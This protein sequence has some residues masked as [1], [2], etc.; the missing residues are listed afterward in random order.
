MTN[1]S[2]V[3][4]PKMTRD[5]GC[6]FKTCNIMGAQPKTKSVKVYKPTLDG[7]SLYYRSKRKSC[8]K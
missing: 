3:E 5:D 1:W 2:K 4:A 8:K 6:D 7:R